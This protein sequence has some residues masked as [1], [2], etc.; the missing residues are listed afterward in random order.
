MLRFLNAARLSQM[1][2]GVYQRVRLALGG[3]NMEPVRM[4]AVERQLEGRLP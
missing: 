2:D 3:V 4:Q 1:K